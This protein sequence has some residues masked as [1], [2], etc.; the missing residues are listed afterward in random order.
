MGDLLHG[1]PA[2]MLSHSVSGVAQWK[3]I[4]IADKDPVT[5]HWGLFWPAFSE[6]GPYQ[7]HCGFYQDAGG[8]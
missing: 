8:V 6:I 4:Y 1:F 5:T 2:V 3:V 7:Q